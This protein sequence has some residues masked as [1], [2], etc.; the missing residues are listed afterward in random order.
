LFVIDWFVSEGRGQI[1]L[2]D[3]F[4]ITTE[5]LSITGTSQRH[6][7]RELVKGIKFWKEL[8]WVQGSQGWAKCLRSKDT[9]EIRDPFL[10]IMIFGL[11]QKGKE[12]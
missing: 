10:V 8:F 11:T 1:S 7:A 12:H 9:H 3:L 4:P 6:V 5:Y 2:F